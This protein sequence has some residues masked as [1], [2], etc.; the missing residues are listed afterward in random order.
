MKQNFSNRIISIGD[1]GFGCLLTIV[2][3]SLVLGSVGLQW[4][5]NSVLIVIA[6]L[7]ITP[8]LA[9]WGLRWWLQKN[10]VQDNCPVCNYTLTGFNNNNLRCANCGEEL[11][12]EAGKFIRETPPGTIEVDVVEVEVEVLD[13]D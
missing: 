7:I 5:V 4:V 11:K 3:V 10:L 13:N 2:L 12:V 9:L 1:S 6:L 8:I